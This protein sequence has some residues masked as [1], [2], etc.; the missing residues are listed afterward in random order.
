MKYNKLV[1]DCIPEIIRAQGK[2]C[3]CR[4]LTETV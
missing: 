1:R 3:L 2:E 4:M